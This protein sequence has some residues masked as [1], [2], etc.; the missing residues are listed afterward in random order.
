MAQTRYFNGCLKYGITAINLDKD[1]KIPDWEWIDE[2][3]LIA[4]ET[5]MTGEEIIYEKP[6]GG[7]QQVPPEE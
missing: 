6:N 2:A 3:Q 7:E 1:G 5:A 4:A